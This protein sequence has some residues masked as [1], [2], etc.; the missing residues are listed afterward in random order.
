MYNG[1]KKKCIITCKIHGDFEQLPL[2]HLKS[3]GC[4][5]CGI[6]S[7]AKKQS[8]VHK[9]TFIT[10]AS[11]IHNGFYDYSKF[12]YISNDDKGIIICPLH[13]EFK[14]T[15][16]HHI[17]RKQ[18]C[19]DCGTEAM[20]QKQSEEA[21]RNFKNKAIKRHDGIYDYSKFV[22]ISSGKKSI[23]ICNK[24]LHEFYQ[25]PEDHL[26][27]RGC[28]RCA[29]YGFNQFEKAILYLGKIDNNLFKIGITN[30]TVK[31]RYQKEYNLFKDVYII[32]F[33]SGMYCKEIEQEILEKTIN[34]QYKGNSIFSKTTNLEIR[35]IED[36]LILN[37]FKSYIQIGSKIEKIK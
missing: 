17:N 29:K 18:G 19:P 24:C 6:Q 26:R 32:K 25:T 20:A 11:K 7:M 27:G 14:Q 13:E 5:D 34:F 12:I 22:Y 37:I 10:K 9:E 36:E 8:K 33:D 31:E 1:S 15:P 30:R 4:N 23:I 16:V 35:E 3:K 2:N 28:S 21:R